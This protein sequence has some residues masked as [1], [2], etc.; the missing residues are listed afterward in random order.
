MKSN[1]IFVILCF[2]LSGGIGHAAPKLALGP[3]TDPALPKDAQCGTYEVFENR[4]AKTGRKIPLR[5]VVLPA[6]GPDR[7]PDPVVYFAGGPG[8]SSVEQGVYLRKF[9]E[10][11]RQRRDFLFIDA[12]GTGG[13]APWPRWSARPSCSA[14]ES[15]RSPSAGPIWSPSWG[16]MRARTAWRSR[17]ISWKGGST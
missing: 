1:A 9:L 11:L 8:G 3:C 12:R 6:L 13:S 17:S 16:A 5:V 14:W 15:P 2:C 4:T 7:Q 10:P